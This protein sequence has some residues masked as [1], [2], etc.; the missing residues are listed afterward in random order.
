LKQPLEEFLAAKA[1]KSFQNSIKFESTS[2]MN[3]GIT[4]LSPVNIEISIHYGIPI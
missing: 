3:V 1:N 4:I 2:Y